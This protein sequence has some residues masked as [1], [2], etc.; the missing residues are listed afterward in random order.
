MCQEAAVRHLQYCPQS[1]AEGTEESASGNQKRFVDRD[2]T[3]I[4]G[5]KVHDSQG[6]MMRIAGFPTNK[7]ESRESISVTAETE[8]QPKLPSQHIQLLRQVPK[9][10]KSLLRVHLGQSLRETFCAPAFQEN[11][12]GDPRL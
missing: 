11:Y 10:V 5:C 3:T 7:T 1:R 9:S 6:G 8:E 4:F 2:W 12:R